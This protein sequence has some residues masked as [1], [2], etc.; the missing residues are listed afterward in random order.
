MA[1]I[2]FELQRMIDQGQ[3]LVARVR[4]YACAGLISSG[5]WIM[6]IATLGVLS[7]FGPLVTPQVEYEMF[8]GL[9]TYS[10]AFSLIT[11]G[12]LQMTATRRVADL[13]YA[14]HHDRVLPAFN[15]S[16]IL[17]GVV[18][19][20][21]GSV[22]CAVAGLPIGL[23]FVAVSLYV[24]VSLSW[25]ALIWL[26]VTREYDDILKAYAFGALAGLCALPLLGKWTDARGLLA[27]YT[28]GQAVT[29]VLLVRTIVR[30]MEAGGRRSYE[31]LDSLRAF[32]RLLIIGVAYNA[33]IWI[34]KIVFWLLNGTGPH[35]LVQFH[36][37]Y[38]TCTFLAYLT[39]I[40]ALAVNLVRVETSFYEC[41]RS[42]YGA[43]LGGRPLAMIDQQRDRMFRNM[44]GG[45][46]RLL[47][48]QGA[49]TVLIMIFAPYLVGAVGL[50]ETAV[51]VFRAA[52]LGAFFHV[53]L[54]I[55]VLMQLYFDLRKA[56]LLTSL[57]F[58]ALNGVFAAWSVEAGVATYGLGYAA[59]ALVSLLLGYA[60]LAGNLRRLDYM[61]F[62][63]QPIEAERASPSSESEDGPGAP[64]SRAVQPRERVG[65]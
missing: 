49:I 33:A 37:L 1:G 35:P 9:I 5:P 52:C 47:R 32:P 43:I 48:V 23:S 58:L 34:D 65:A 21:V 62:T 4:G 59:A 38:D 15:A 54:L 7:I 36:P 11:V 29:L 55:T 12:L 30:G 42:Y 14:G 61:T 26:G 60:L 18:Q 50:P 46:V 64:A 51:R 45:M 41:Y 24:V 20:I 2:G 19:A 28:A 25:L 44:E 13:L 56:A 16:L 3:G 31:I 22:F 10:F 57:V 39:V 27:V 6:T 53:M 40:P 17:T 8:R 63:Q